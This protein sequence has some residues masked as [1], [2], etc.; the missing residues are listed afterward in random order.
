MKFEEFTGLVAQRANAPRDRAETLVRTTLGTLAERIS[1]GETRDLAD[2]L[3][4]EL[5]GPLAGAAEP[6]QPFGVDEFVRRVGE[7]A[8]LDTDAARDGAR[9]VLVTLREAVTPGLFDDVTSQLPQEYSE[10][11]GPI[12]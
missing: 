10:L 5:K 4:E 6:A 11:T 12:I 7:R 8:G 1:G 9:A 3:P 2:Q